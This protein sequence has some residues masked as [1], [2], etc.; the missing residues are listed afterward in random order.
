MRKNRKQSILSNNSWAKYAAGAAAVFG[1]QA[2]LSAE[3]TVVDVGQSIL[4]EAGVNQGNDGFDRFGP[5]SLGAPGASF[6]MVHQFEEQIDGEGALFVKANSNV[7]FVGA[8]AGGAGFVYAQ[9][10]DFN[11]AV[12]ARSNFN[13]DNNLSLPYGVM[14]WGGGYDNS[15]F[16]DAGTSYLAFRFDVGNGTQYGWA[17]V[18]MSGA[19]ENSAVLERYAYGMVG[20]Q[21][22]VGVIPEPGSLGV[23]ALGSIGLLAWRKKRAA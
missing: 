23:L 8:A 18:T 22:R 5:Y 9:N 13:I 4:G 20:D 1:C 10:L 12:S 16:L 15:E 21:V 11:D 7:S 14:A 19:G 2:N 3:L 17:E 6:S